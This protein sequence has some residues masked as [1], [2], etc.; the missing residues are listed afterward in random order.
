MRN[1]GTDS[2]SLVPLATLTSWKR[3]QHEVDLRGP[4]FQDHS[5]TFPGPF[6]D[7]SRSLPFQDLFRTFPGPSQDL[8]RGWGSEGLPERLSGGGRFAQLMVAQLMVAK[9]MVAKLQLQLHLC[10][11]KL[12]K[13]VLV[14]RTPDLHHLIWAFPPSRIN[15]QHSSADIRTSSNHGCN[16]VLFQVLKVHSLLTLWASVNNNNAD[17]SGS[18][19]A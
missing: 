2:I 12:K 11:L 18:V 14:G 8:S 9:L 4:G 1:F 15:E 16:Q 10:W 17:S 3:G 7:H 19:E 6:Q 13:E 5:R